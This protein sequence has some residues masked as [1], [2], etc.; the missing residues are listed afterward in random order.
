MD[1][2]HSYIIAAKGRK[3]FEYSENEHSVRFFQQLHVPPFV[4]RAMCMISPDV[5]VKDDIY[6][7][8]KVTFYISDKSIVKELT[9]IFQVKI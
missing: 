2:A 6:V 3:C 1:Y 7:G 5:L 8:N 9:R 4:I